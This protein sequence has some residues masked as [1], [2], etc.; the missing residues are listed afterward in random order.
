[1]SVW[2]SLAA[3][4]SFV[5]S[6]G[7][8]L[9]VM[10]R[11]REWFDKLGDLYL[12]LWWLPAGCVPTVAGAEER[13]ETA[14]RDGAV[15]GGL[16]LPH[17]LPAAVERGLGAAA[18]RRPRAL[19]RRLANSQQAPLEARPGAR[20]DRDPARVAGE[21]DAVDAAGVQAPGCRRPAR[22]NSRARARSG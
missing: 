5:Y 16:Q 12:V 8:H 15:A 10:R 14:A 7:P 2:E 21:G 1:M 4:R 19:P 22:A 3:L 6:S 17:A 9:D 20:H 11:R 13:L 18:P